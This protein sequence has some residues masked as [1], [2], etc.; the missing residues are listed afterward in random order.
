MNLHL[1]YH[2]ALLNSLSGEV[3]GK[4]DASGMKY[5]LAASYSAP[6]PGMK[7]GSWMAA[8]KT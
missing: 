5:A 3:S 6:T 8:V 1:F 2:F 4:L 7:G